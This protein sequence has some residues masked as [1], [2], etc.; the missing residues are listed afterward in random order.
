MK[1]LKTIVKE[2]APR[3]RKITQQEMSCLLAKQPDFLEQK[4][5]LS[6]VVTTKNHLIDYFPKYHCELNAIEKVWGGSK[7]ITRNECDFTLD[8][9]RKVVPESLKR[10]CEGD[11]IKRYF[12]SSFE[13]MK[14]YRD[15]EGMTFEQVQHIKKQYKS[16]RKCVAC[17]S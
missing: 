10:V 14:A 17:F 6:E 5:W 13:Y 2:R 9:L 16:H 1:G 15:G 12:R 3:P 4:E 7:R 11:S 8:G